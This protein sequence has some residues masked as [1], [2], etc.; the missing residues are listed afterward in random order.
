[1]SSGT[2]AGIERTGGPEK[3]KSAIPK[4]RVHA[5]ALCIIIFAEVLESKSLGME[6][7]L[8]DHIVTRNDR[9]KAR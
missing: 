4:E 1:M 5:Y 7:D 2:H 9:L 8:A 6:Y 3:A